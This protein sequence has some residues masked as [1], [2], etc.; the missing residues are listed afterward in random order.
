MLGGRNCVAVETVVPDG[1]RITMCR[2]AE[3]CAV[4]N[5]RSSLYVYSATAKLI[6]MYFCVP[7]ACQNNYI[8]ACHL[9]KQPFQKT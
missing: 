7:S 9:H 1:E 4:Q 6:A 8:T 3:D 2:S 5:V